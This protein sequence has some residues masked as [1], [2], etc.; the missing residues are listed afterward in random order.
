MLY[1]TRLF[2]NMD[3]A[4]EMD[5]VPTFIN[6]AELGLVATQALLVVLPLIL[7]AIHG[8]VTRGIKIY[9]DK[10]G[11]VLPPKN[12]ARY[13]IAIAI[14]T[15]HAI[16]VYLIT[17]VLYVWN[18]N[19]LEMS[20]IENF[21]DFAT[22]LWRFGGIIF[23]LGIFL[24][25]LLASILTALFSAWIIGVVKKK[26][27]RGLNTRPTHAAMAAM[28]VFI[29]SFAAVIYPTAYLW[30]TDQE[31]IWERV[32][33][34]EGEPDFDFDFEEGFDDNGWLDDESWMDD[35]FGEELMLEESMLEELGLDFD[36]LELEDVDFGDESP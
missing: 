14:G 7:L 10:D 18:R 34:L 6:I 8:G 32:M 22:D 15:A 24:P 31:R 21:S 33:E 16:V 1:M 4:V 25:L 28:L 11:K 35:E 20:M 19:F 36:G 23:P 2:E 29:L 13:L 5:S 12:Y 3:P 26:H 9:T 17:V 30:D 27:D